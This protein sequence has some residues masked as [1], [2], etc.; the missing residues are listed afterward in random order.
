MGRERFGHW[1][2]SPPDIRGRLTHWGRALHQG[3][4]RSLSRRTR[5][6]LPTTSCGESPITESRSW[7]EPSIVRLVE[8]SFS[9]VDTCPLPVVKTRSPTARPFLHASTKPPFPLKANPSVPLRHPEFAPHV[10]RVTAI[11]TRLRSRVPRHPGSCN[12]ATPEAWRSEAQVIPTSRLGGP[13]GGAA[14]PHSHC[15]FESVAGTEPSEE[16]QRRVE[17][18]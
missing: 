2:S 18:E 15:R 5:C 16:R 4:R 10:R 13:M 9:R 8:G 12:G 17:A 11:E 1:E 14:L 3:D 7:G 6:F